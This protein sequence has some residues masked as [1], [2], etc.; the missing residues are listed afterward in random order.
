MD[1]SLVKLKE[2]VKDQKLEVLSQGGDGC[3]DLLEEIVRAMY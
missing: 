1:S 3:V 2:W